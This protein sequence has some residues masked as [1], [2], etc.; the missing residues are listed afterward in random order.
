[1]CSSDLGHH[2][3]GD[4]CVEDTLYAAQKSLGRPGLLKAGEVC[5]NGWGSI[6]SIG[7]RSNRGETG[8]A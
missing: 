1:M 6:S 3:G 4:K 2:E 5:R 7:R 8:N